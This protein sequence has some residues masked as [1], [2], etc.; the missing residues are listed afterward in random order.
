M[1]NPRRSPRFSM[2]AG[3]I[4]LAACG[5]QQDKNLPPAAYTGP[6]LTQRDLT[7]EGPKMGDTG[8]VVLEEQTSV[9]RFPGGV[10]I[11]RLVPADGDP[12]DEP[13]RREWWLGS[14]PEEKATHWTSL[15]NTLNAVQEV[16]ILDS[17]S[18]QWRDCDLAKVVTTAGRMNASVCVIWGPAEAPADHA[19]LLGVVMAADTGLPVACVRAEAGPADFLEPA[20]DQV[21]ADLR[22]KDVNHLV[23]RKFENQVR[24]CVR[25]LIARDQPT[26][27]MRPSPWMADG[28]CLGAPPPPPGYVTPR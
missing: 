7:V 17:Q 13:P 2:L 14:I 23:A 12:L 21:K 10:A 20:P 19:A 4:L 18:V 22:H 25:E 26:T 28:T 5:C 3:G 16:L 27:T 15:F 24:R 1:F 9:G 11:A 8:Y 6:T